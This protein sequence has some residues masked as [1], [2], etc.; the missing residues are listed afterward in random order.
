MVY[1][2][3]YLLVPVSTRKKKTQKVTEKYLDQP[4][5]PGH[6]L[7]AHTHTGCPGKLQHTPRAHPRQSP[8]PTMKGIPL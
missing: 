6:R 8:E 5:T 1:I 2:Y 7:H 4:R 3:V